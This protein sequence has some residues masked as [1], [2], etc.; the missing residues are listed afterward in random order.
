MSDERTPDERYKKLCTQLLQHCTN[1]N[2]RGARTS[3]SKAYK[4]AV[5]L[6]KQYGEIEAHRVK[7][8]EIDV[9]NTKEL[10]EELATIH[11]YFQCKT[12]LRHWNWLLDTNLQRYPHKLQAHV[13]APWT[14]RD[15]CHWASCDWHLGQTTFSFIFGLTHNFFCQWWDLIYGFA[16]FFQGK[17]NRIHF[18]FFYCHT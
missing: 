11:N 8:K 15:F 6:E 9:S 13:L 7:G 1:T 3:L 18:C 4:F 17:N 10:L 5:E 2:L 12:I 16:Q 14:E